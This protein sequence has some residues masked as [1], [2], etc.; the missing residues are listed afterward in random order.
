MQ[1]RIRLKG[2]KSRRIENLVGNEVPE[3]D[4][5]WGQLFQFGYGK[6]L[7]AWIFTQAKRLEGYSVEFLILLHEEADLV[8]RYLG[9]SFEREPVVQMELQPIPEENAKA[10]L[11]EKASLHNSRPFCGM[12]RVLYRLR[13]G[14]SAAVGCA[15]LRR[16]LAKSCAVSTL[17]PLCRS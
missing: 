6:E 3:P 15:T 7:E 11:S 5:Q 1:V 2:T 9:A 16:S 10:L 12:F 13:Q 4:S 17:R 8:E 14:R